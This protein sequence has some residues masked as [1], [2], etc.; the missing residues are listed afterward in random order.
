MAMT[1]K[2]T[3]SKAD[4]FRLIKGISRSIERH[5]HEAG[6]LT[7]GQLASLK[8][9]G[10]S[11][12]LG[13]LNG[14]STKRISKE[15][16]I[17]QARALSSQSE[18]QELK[19]ETAGEEILPSIQRA[20]LTSFV[21]E[22][23]R[24]EEGKTKRTKVMHVDT[25]HEDTWTGWQER[26]LVDFFITRSGICP[27][28]AEADL[29]TAPPIEHTRKARLALSMISAP[30][31]AAGQIPSPEPS[32][33]PL[34]KSIEITTSTGRPALQESMTVPFHPRTDTGVLSSN[35]TFDVHLALD[36]REIDAGGRKSLGYKAAIYA[37]N[38]K[39]RLRQSVGEADGLLEATDT[40]IIIVNGKPL[41]QGLYRLQAVVGLSDP[42]SQSIIQTGEKLLQVA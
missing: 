5:L 39:G 36:L 21:V 28:G 4:N 26:R 37:K 29:S 3:L 12:I 22:L 14:V 16:W 23:L 33:E 27:S 19:E 34:P 18:L 38:L 35:Q 11:T 41:P 42:D 8:P 17:E 20:G 6:I 25:G 31:T 9:N 32:I 7:Y 13:D 40:P 30:V 15:N 1:S 2:R 10:I 24:D